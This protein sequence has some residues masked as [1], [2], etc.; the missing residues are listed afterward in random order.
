[1]IGGRMELPR[2]RIAASVLLVVLMLASVWTTL[3]FYKRL[4]TSDAEAN[5]TFRLSDRLSTLQ[6]VETPTGLRF[7]FKKN[8]RNILQTPDEFAREVA[9]NET[10]RAKGGWFFRF[11][12]ITSTTGIFWVTLGLAGQLAFTGRMIVQWIASE[13]QRQSV[14]PTVFWW[15][16]LAGSSLLIV[17]FLWR[18]DVVGVLGQATGWFIYIRN[19]WL[20]YQRGRPVGR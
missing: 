8:G 18:V 7:H 6:V 12:D 19:L 13:K 11:F 14:V 2:I 10:R 4:S 1:M 15:M 16:S 5:R 9:R 20:I 17:Y 3:T